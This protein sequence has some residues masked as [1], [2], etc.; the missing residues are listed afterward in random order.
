LAIDA[1]ARYGVSKVQLVAERRTRLLLNFQLGAKKSADRQFDR[2][3][4]VADST[5]LT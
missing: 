1:R 4:T 3:G 2:R 5:S